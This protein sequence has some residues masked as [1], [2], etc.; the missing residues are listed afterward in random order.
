MFKIQ[1][2]EHTHMHT[3]TTTHYTHTH[4]HVSQGNGTEDTVFEKRKI[5]QGR[6]KRKHSIHSCRSGEGNYTGSQ[7][8]YGVR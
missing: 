6:F 7:S 5:F 8:N 4:T 1:R 3:N 2:M